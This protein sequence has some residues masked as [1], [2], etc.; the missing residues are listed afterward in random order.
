MEI[1]FLLFRMVL[2]KERK[3]KLVWEGKKIQRC[4]DAVYLRLGLSDQLEQPSGR[5]AYPEPAKGYL[6]PQVI[7]VE[8]L[9][10]V[11]GVG[12]PVMIWRVAK[13]NVI[14]IEERESIVG[15]LR[16]VS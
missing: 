1:A 8:R 10:I 4:V 12:D 11:D 13:S 15:M 5:L 2:I 3:K 7:S 6:P 9:A 16:S 14:M